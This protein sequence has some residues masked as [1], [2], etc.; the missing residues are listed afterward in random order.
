[1]SL[2][3]IDG[4]LRDEHLIGEA[5]RG[6]AAGFTLGE[7]LAQ[8]HPE[9]QVLEGQNTAL[10]DVQAFADAG[11]CV[12]EARR[13]HHHQYDTDW[14]PD[15]GARR[16]PSNAW[17]QVSWQGQSLDVILLTWETDYASRTRY[18][19]LAK[20][21]D[22]CAAF[23]EAVCRWNQEVHGE[24]LVYAG[25]CFQKSARL[26]DSIQAAS[27]DQLVLE[28]TLERQIRDDFTRFLASRETYEEHGVP[29][30]RGALFL[31]PPGNG[32]TLCV[33]ALVRELGIPCI[34]VQSFKAQYA[35]DQA[36]IEEVFRRARAS[37][38]CILVLEDIDSLLSDGSRSFF[39]NELDG[40]A[41]NTGLVTLATTNHAERL[42]PAIVERPSR[43]DRKYHF[44]L[45]APAA[46][47]AYVA[48][49][50]ARLRPA[51]RLS[52]AGQAQIV[53][54]TEGF[55]F[56]YVQELFVSSMIAWM[57]RRDSVGILPV[58]LEQ[59]ELLRAQMKHSV[60]APEPPPIANPDGGLLGALLRP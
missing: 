34:Y 44:D 49:W 5:L 45:P 58:A 28:G 30:K 52:E 17:L 57:A 56:A 50:N 15:L 38:P 16:R 35:T 43:F 29:W 23:F 22:T 36:S 1:M 53:S 25:G 26:Y 9:V 60:E 19:V 47:A 3:S 31:G 27:F 59:I 37:S 20:S 54:L 7:R 40:F 13:D 8:L 24:I 18:F 32:K 42:D 4:R 33:K 51:L 55:S 46:R 10:F 2:T 48:L 41:V 39:L 11:H 12:L 6:P 21:R 14:I